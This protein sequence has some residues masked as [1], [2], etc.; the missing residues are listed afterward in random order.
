M[1][2]CYKDDICCRKEKRMNKYVTGEVG[3]PPHRSHT[4]RRRQQRPSARE[5]SSL[6]EDETQSEHQCNLFSSF[7]YI[8]VIM[9]AAPVDIKLNVWHYR[10]E[11]VHMDLASTDPMKGCAQIY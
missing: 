4:S 10:T 3:E 7:K 2:A 8:Q 6:S 9:E 11:Y 5:M 1:Q